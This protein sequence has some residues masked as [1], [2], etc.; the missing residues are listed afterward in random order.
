MG[1]YIEKCGIHEEHIG[2]PDVLVVEAALKLEGIE[3]PDSGFDLRDGGD[4]FGSERRRD[5]CIV[6]CSCAYRAYGAHS[7]DAIRILMIRVI[8]QLIRHKE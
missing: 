2:D 1:E 5:G 6:T 3:Y 8:A 7:V 4:Q